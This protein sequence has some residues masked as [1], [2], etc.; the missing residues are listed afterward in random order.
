M[1]RAIGKQFARHFATGEIL[2]PHLNN[3]F[4]LADFP[5]EIPLTLRPNKEQD[6][7]FHPSSALMCERA[8]FAKM[9]GELPPETTTLDQQKTFMF[10]R[11]VHELIQWIVVEQLGFSTWDQ[12]EKDSDFALTTAAGNPY[13]VRG[14]PDIARMD[15][16]G[17]SAPVLLDIKSIAARL[18][19]LAELPPSLRKKYL[20]QTQIYLEFEDLELGI[21]LMTEKDSPHRFREVHVQRDGA[22]VDEIMDGWEYVT[23]CLAADELPDCTCGDEACPAAGVYQ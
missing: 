17:Q 7:A 21:L 15:I 2:V 9:R 11:Y 5:D 20:A 4:A 19:G 1:V 12:V 14:F 6:D 22:M 3:W 10:G 16:P 8:L 23:D 18:Y 13:R